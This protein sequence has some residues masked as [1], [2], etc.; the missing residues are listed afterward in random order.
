MADVQVGSDERRRARVRRVEDVS[1]V[2]EVA[3]MVRDA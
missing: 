3:W 1:E 2:M